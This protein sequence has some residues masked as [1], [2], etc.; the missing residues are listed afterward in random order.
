M[1]MSVGVGWPVVKHKTRQ[2]RF[3]PFPLQPLVDTGR[4]PLGQALWLPLR[5]IG[6]HGKF[7][8]AHKYRFFVV[9]TI[10]PP[11]ICCATASGFSTR[12]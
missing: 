10:W 6:S 2:A 12:K 5:E 3:P 8:L 11:K 4:L 7:C 9:H 1:Y